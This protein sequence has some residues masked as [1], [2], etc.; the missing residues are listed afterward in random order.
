VSSDACPL[1]H[2]I[3][4]DHP[5]DF[6]LLSVMHRFYLFGILLDLMLSAFQCELEPRI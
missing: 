2:S 4:S 5:V 6:I 1:R 3:C